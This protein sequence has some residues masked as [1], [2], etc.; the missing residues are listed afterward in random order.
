MMD[1]C[2]QDINVH[3]NQEI[4]EQNEREE[5]INQL[6]KLQVQLQD[7]LNKMLEQ[8]GKPTVYHIHK[9]YHRKEP[10]VKA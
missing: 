7:E 2:E 9:H 8:G 6:M 10:E 5:K 4:M 1:K 3:H